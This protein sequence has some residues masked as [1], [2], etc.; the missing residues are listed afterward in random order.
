MK[1]AYIRSIP[2]LSAKRQNEMADADGVGKRERYE[3]KRSEP[4]DIRK[5]AVMSIRPSDELWVADLTVL[6][7]NRPTMVAFLNWSNKEH[8]VAIYESRTKRVSLPPHHGQGMAFDACTRWANRNRTFGTMTAAEAGSEGGKEAA[9][10]KRVGYPPINFC[11]AI[12]HDPANANMKSADLAE[13]VAAACRK[14][15][16]KKTYSE[17]SL[18]RHCKK[19][20]VD[21]GRKVKTI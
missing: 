3:E 16:Y 13:K 2:G 21:S 12:W 1:R 18:Y 19:R 14:A 6:A 9:K 20:S 8:P 11:K 17:T 10:T 15:G 4:T 5:S 7:D